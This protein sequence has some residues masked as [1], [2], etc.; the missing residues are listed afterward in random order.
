MLPP[1]MQPA[2]VCFTSLPTFLI[3]TCSPQLTTKST[4]RA[5]VEG[6]SMR[7]RRLLVLLSNAFYTKKRSAAVKRGA[8]S[9]KK[10]PLIERQVGSPTP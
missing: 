6:R 10:R 4:A 8:V 9:P 3:L 1:G 2:N 7:E 5:W